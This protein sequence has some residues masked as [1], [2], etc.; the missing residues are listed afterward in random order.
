MLS[1]AELE[2]IEARANAATP[3]PWA[4]AKWRHG[5]VKSEAINGL[6]A[7]TTAPNDAEFIAAARTDIPT[8]LSEVR[9]QQSSL[10]GASI[11]QTNMQK[12][13]DRLR[14]EVEMIKGVREVM[15]DATIAAVYLTQELR[16]STLEADLAHAR[17]SANKSLA[18]WYLAAKPEKRALAEALWERSAPQCEQP[19]SDGWEAGMEV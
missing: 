5:G 12:E 11:W 17:H 9:S 18:A 19:A 14:E 15:D 8:L 4:I 1:D 6:V 7:D 3:G 2:A 16:I 10:R 13:I